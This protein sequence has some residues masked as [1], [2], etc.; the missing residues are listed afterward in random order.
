M[1]KIQFSGLAQY[2]PQHTHTPFFQDY[3]GELVPESKTDPDFT[4]ARNSEWQCHM[5]V[6]T[7]LQTD[8]HASTPLLCFFTGRMPFLPPNQQRQSTE[9]ISHNNQN[10]KFCGLN[11]SLLHRL[12]YTSIFKAES[13]VRIS[14]KHTRMASAVSNSGGF[15]MPKS[16]GMRV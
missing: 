13:V 7:L 4:E 1:L 9:G 16:C 8:N 11:A 15:F 14:K 12:Q 6:C 3:P 2:I 5:Q 10:S